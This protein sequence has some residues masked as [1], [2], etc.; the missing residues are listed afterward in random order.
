MAFQWFCAPRALA[1]VEVNGDIARS[2]TGISH[3]VRASLALARCDFVAM[4]GSH[5]DTAARRFA[6]GQLG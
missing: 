3:F 5:C 6:S 1:Q 4:Q 2:S